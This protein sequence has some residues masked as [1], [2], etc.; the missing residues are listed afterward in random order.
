MSQRA[1]QRRSLKA[2]TKAAFRAAGQP[3]RAG[4]KALSQA[5]SMIFS[6]RPSSGRGG[7][8]FGWLPGSQYDYEKEAGD[9]WLNSI[10]LPCL[11]WIETNFPE[12]PLIVRQ[13]GKAGKWEPVEGHPLE[14]LIARPNDYYGGDYLWA[15][16]NLDLGLDGNAY[17]RK[18]RNSLGKVIELWWI[19][20]LMIEPKRD[21]DGSSF[22][23]HYEYRVNGKA[24]RL[25]VEDVVHFRDGVDRRNDL[26]GM[27]RLKA[28]LREVCTDNECATF[29]AA[30]MRNFGVPGVVIS[31]EPT[32]PTEGPRKGFG[33]D[34]REEIVELWKQKFTGESR[35]EPFVF[36]R[37]VRVA[38]AGLSPA[39]LVIDK[40]RRVPEE[41]ISAAIGVPAVVVGLGAGL[42]HSC[43]A[44]F[45]EAREAAY[46]SGIMP[47]QRIYA[48]AMDVQLLPEFEYYVK[49]GTKNQRVHFDV[50]EVRALQQDRND[51]F[52]RL[53]LACGGPFLLPDEARAEAGYGALPDAT[54]QTLRDPKPTVLTPKITDN[55][56]PG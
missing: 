47:R 17:W 20:S 19:P 53:E 44:N 28:T 12:A 18:V 56:K 15:A 38:N 29:S 45:K 50:S 54:G 6:G 27:S 14:E 52:T 43:Y 22:I 30:I 31:P 40:M 51:M 25:E 2:S 34:Q 35:G 42:E 13:R 24:H 10:V 16:T 26:K 23:S 39:D 1:T 55:V 46:E 9:L 33:Q 32:G 21:A 37:P 41:R 48:M 4:F 5:T 8:F 36:G 3:F 7:G 11:K 49:G